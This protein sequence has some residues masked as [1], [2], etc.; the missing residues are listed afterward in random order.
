VSSSV[1]DVR[2]GAVPAE[3]G[4]ATALEKVGGSL[5]SMAPAARVV[6]WGGRVGA[7]AL[8]AF[9][10]VA[11]TE[12]STMGLVCAVLVAAV[13]LAALS[14]ASA[15]VPF[16]L[17]TPAAAA[18]GTLGGLVVAS[19]LDLW[20]PGVALGPGLLFLTAA[21]IF[22]SWTLWELVVECAATR[23]RRVLVIGSVACTNAVV[24]GLD[25]AGQCKFAV[26]GSVHEA[27]PAEGPAAAPKLGS[28]TALAEIVAAHSPDL[29]VLADERE[30]ADVLD[31]LLDI[32]GHTFRVVTVPHFFEHALGRVPL[33]HVTPTWFM[34]MVHLRQR[35]YSRL[36]KRVFDLSVAFLALVAS[37]PL[38]VLVAAAVRI[39]GSPVL[40]RQTRLGERGECFTVVKF[41]TMRPD[42]ESA[43]F[44][45]WAE[46]RDPRVTG[47]GRVLRKTRLDEL[48]QLWNVVRGEMSIVGPRPE[49][50][51]F[52][53]V[54][55]RSVP[56]WNR[57]L[58]I[59]PGITGWAQVRTPYAADCHGAANKLS[60]DLWYL[61]HRSIF[62]D[63]AICAKTA[64]VMLFGRGAR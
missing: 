61:R 17:G 54:L 33:H 7:V 48:P 57:R 53:E 58:L 47:V 10:L 51:E 37:A 16:A 3:L 63:L 18:A 28:V 35:A 15:A 34:S 19:S 2:V 32:A 42:A 12:R 64:S 9:T 26:I 60:H 40:Y 24:E 62:V 22:S 8:P 27:E 49:R 56:Y 50:P 20:I 30:P 31:R 38:F 55:E 52:V 11:I 5:G 21:G 44:A 43:S 6:H 29:I 46:A 4:A 45:L 14:K 1:P 25:E 41:R 39:T 59:K 23:K 13:W 36:A